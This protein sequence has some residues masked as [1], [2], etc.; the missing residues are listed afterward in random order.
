MVHLRHFD[1]AAGLIHGN[2]IAP[3]RPEQLFNGE[4]DGGMPEIYTSRSAAHML[5]TKCTKVV[6]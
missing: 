1:D 2:L 4:C 6:K 5:G 3:D